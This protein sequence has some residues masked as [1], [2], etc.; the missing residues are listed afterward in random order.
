MRPIPTSSTTA[1]L[2]TERAGS[3]RR[4]PCAGEEL[5]AVVRQHRRLLLLRPGI[6][7]ASVCFGSLQLCSS[8]TSYGP[9]P[10]R[11]VMRATAAAVLDRP[12]GEQRDRRAYRTACLCR[13]FNGLVAAVSAG[14]GISAVGAAMVPAQLADSTVSTGCLG[15][16]TSTSSS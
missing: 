11:D 4:R 12:D 16:D 13:G 7:I 10:A 9:E 15:S 5:C 1:L 8:P 6:A 14:I 3:G 2:A